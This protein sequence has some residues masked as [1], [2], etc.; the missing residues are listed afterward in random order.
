[1]STDSKSTWQ[2]RH[3]FEEASGLPSVLGSY[4]DF[5]L[6]DWFC[7]L[8]LWTSLPIAIWLHSG[9]IGL[10]AHWQAPSRIACLLQ[11]AKLSLQIVRTSRIFE[12]SL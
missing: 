3:R 4:M 5:R 9:W 7:C 10:L 1:V 11:S 2:G 12:V 6:A 8:S